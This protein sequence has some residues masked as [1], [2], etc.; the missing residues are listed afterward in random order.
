[1]VMLYVDELLLWHHH[2]DHHADHRGGQDVTQLLLQCRSA[3]AFSLEWLQRQGVQTG[4]RDAAP[5][6]VGHPN[7]QAPNLLDQRV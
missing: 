3:L 5:E 4:L 2:R 1:M 6:G 7:P